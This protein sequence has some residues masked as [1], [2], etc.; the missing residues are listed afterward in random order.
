MNYFR[1]LFILSISIGSAKASICNEI[2]NPLFLSE[3]KSAELFSLPFG[4]IN[5]VRCSYPQLIS[6]SDAFKFDLTFLDAIIELQAPLIN[7]NADYGK[8]LN[9]LLDF[10]IVKKGLKYQRENLFQLYKIKHFPTFKNI[11]HTMLRSGLNL[12]QAYSYKNTKTNRY[13]FVHSPFI[14]ALNAFADREIVNYLMNLPSFDPN[15]FDHKYGAPFNWFIVNGVG[16]DFAEKLMENP[17]FDSYAPAVVYIENNFY[18]TT[19]LGSIIDQFFMRDSDNPNIFNL[20][21]DGKGLLGDN[22]DGIKHARLLYLLNDGKNF[23]GIAYDQ[24][25]RQKKSISEYHVPGG[26]DQEQYKFL[27]IPFASGLSARMVFY[28]HFGDCTIFDRIYRLGSPSGMSVRIQSPKTTLCRLF[29][30]ENIDIGLFDQVH[31]N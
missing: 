27:N 25:Q 19:F 14:N 21:H 28:H 22:T 6:K 2:A 17:K 30:D 13:D 29:H 8:N 5:N 26:L 11:F 31:G 24:P 20:W 10:L 9:N 3:A 12:N 18:Y 7:E 16:A 1:L 15:Y 23:K 4:A